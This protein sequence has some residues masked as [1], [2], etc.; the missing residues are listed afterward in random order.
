MKSIKD[1]IMLK[2]IVLLTMMA[3]SL[4]ASAQPKSSSQV[5]DKVVAVVGKNIILQSD[6]ESQYL[7]Y[8]MQVGTEGAGSSVRCDILE[9]LLFQ[10][11][12]LNHRF[13]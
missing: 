1:V 6:V 10:K 5:V 8:R 11:L 3:I 2:R 12:M 7:Q 4:A 13:G 9:D